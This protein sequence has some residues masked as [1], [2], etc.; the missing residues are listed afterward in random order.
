[1]VWVGEVQGEL[2]YQKAKKYTKTDG[3]G[4][5]EPSLLAEPNY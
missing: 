4:T 3:G 2:M 5:E 1:M